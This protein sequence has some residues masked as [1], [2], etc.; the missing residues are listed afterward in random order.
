MSVN[1]DAN[2]ALR[3]VRMQL[4]YCCRCSQPLALSHTT[5]THTHQLTDVR[6]RLLLAGRLRV[7]R[8]A[9]G[10]LFGVIV[11]RGRV[12]AS[13]IAIELHALL[14]VLLVVAVDFGV[15]C[16]GAL[17]AAS[18]VRLVGGG[19]HFRLRKYTDLI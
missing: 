16:L 7:V 2:A 1:A 11:V 13:R 9:T 8:I 6:R 18:Q 14:L 4:R 19:N 17:H 12:A 15:L 10:R 5:H 3:S